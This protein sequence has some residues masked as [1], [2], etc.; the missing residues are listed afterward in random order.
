MLNLKLSANLNLKELE[1]F[2]ADES[3]NDLDGKLIADINYQGALMAREKMAVSANGL[4]SLVDTRFRDEKSAVAVNDINGQFELL[5][6]PQSQMS[7][8]LL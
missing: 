1:G 2:I 5:I 4:I 6:D 8:S 3:L 7:G